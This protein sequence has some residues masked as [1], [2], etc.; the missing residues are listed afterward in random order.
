VNP[1]SW[2]N[3]E[4]RFRFDLPTA[5]W[6]DLNIS[7]DVRLLRGGVEVALTKARSNRTLGKV[8]QERGREGGREGQREAGDV[9]TGAQQ[10]WVPLCKSW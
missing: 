4:A 6:Q 5:S 2:R 3:G 8:S 10:Q 7:D 9:L 1:Q